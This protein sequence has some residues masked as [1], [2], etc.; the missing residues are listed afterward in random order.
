MV[1]L[2]TTIVPTLDNLCKW[3]RYVDDAYYIVK[4][5]SV[6]V[7]TYTFLFLQ[8]TKLLRA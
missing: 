4:T 8:A 3:K 2:E 5:D 6:N 1:E 7:S